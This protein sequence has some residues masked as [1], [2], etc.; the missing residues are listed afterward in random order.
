MEQGLTYDDVLLIPGFSSIAS[1]SEVDLSVDLGKGIKFKLPII[2]ANMKHVTGVEMA[3]AMAA[4]GGLGLLHRFNTIDEQVADFKKIVGLSGASVGIKPEDKDRVKALI[5]AGCSIICIDIAHGHSQGCLDMAKWISWEYPDVL[6]IAGNVATA[7]G[8]YA[9]A[10]A[11]VDVVKVGIGGGSI[12]STRIET[13]N[14]VPM[15]T[16]LKWVFGE[17]CDNFGYAANRKFKIIADGGIREGGDVV[18]ALC[19]SDAVMVGNLLAR[20]EES[21]GDR[22]EKDGVLYK[23]YHGSSTH[24]NS[25]V[26][27]V[28][29][30]LPVEGKASDVLQWL[31]EGLQS[32]CSYQGAKNLEELKIRGKFIRITPQGLLESRP[33]SLS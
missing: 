8:A 15:V 31:S 11:G 24:K 13:G 17:A 14:G 10:E 12:C 7:S 22:I 19:L 1:R 5:E 4:A 20:T 32:G 16:S 33:H 29:T 23:S 25:R 2:S 6:L 18:K 28:K 21:P 9:L 30:L 26:E 27:G 3:S